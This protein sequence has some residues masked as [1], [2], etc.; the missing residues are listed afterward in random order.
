NLE[1]YNLDSIFSELITYA[2]TGI[3]GRDAS[4]LAL[5]RSAGIKKICTHDK[6]FKKIPNLEVI[7]PTELNL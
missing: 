5:M 6:A 3:G 2:H 4:I 1:F 7:D